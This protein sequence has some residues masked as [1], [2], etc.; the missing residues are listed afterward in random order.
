MVKQYRALHDMH[1][2]IANLSAANRKQAVWETA[3]ICPSP[4]QVDV[5]PFD[6]ESGVW[7]V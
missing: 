7:I 4:M 5:W 2:D 1:A 3:A 6:L